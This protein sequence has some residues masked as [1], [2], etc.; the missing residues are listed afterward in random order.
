MKRT[1][2]WMAL[3]A[4][5]TITFSGTNALAVEK[6]KKFHNSWAVGGVE[7]VNIA[8][9]F[10]EVRITNKGG[11][12]ITIDVLVTVEAS[13][14]SKANDLLDKISI[15]MQKKG[16][17]VYAKTIIENNFNSQRRFSINYVVNVP[18]DKN[19]EISNKYGNTIVNQ[20][21]ANG[22]FDIQY[23]N[24]T[25]NE[26]KAPGTDNMN[27][28][29]A[30]GK[31]SIETAN[32]LR[33]DLQYS[34]GTVGKIKDLLL[35]SKYS[36]LDLEEGG[37]IHIDSKYDKYDFGKVASVLATTKYTQV[38]I[39]K[40]AKSL[41]IEAGYGSIRVNEISADFESVSVT[42]E[43]GQI[44]LGLGKASYAVD[45]SCEYCGISYPESNFK[46]NKMNERNTQTIDGEVGNGGGGTIYIRSRYGEIRLGD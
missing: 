25:A 44:S 9:K 37:N 10:G 12:Q 32:D 42:N 17:T 4:L 30:Y 1:F 26:L 19:L 16:E 11:N 31:A 46:G 24:L 21:F 13:S 28:R 33:L 18:S 8:N 2:K 5:I 45:A 34:G 35:Q 14:D 43:Y 29:I 41:K 3:L 38:R 6:T 39:E 23:G 20:L 40:L 36:S 15:A 27:V 22:L 7:T